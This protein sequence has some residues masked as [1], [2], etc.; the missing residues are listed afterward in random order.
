MSSVAK[1]EWDQSEADSVLLGWSLW[2]QQ[3]H[4]SQRVSNPFGEGGRS[5]HGADSQQPG[6][7]CALP[8]W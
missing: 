8:P 3:S 2:I 7:L 6:P 4:S 1:C 5:Q